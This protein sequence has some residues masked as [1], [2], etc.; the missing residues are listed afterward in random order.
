VTEI[1]TQGV[2][3]GPTGTIGEPVYLS[4]FIPLTHSPRKTDRFLLRDLYLREGKTASQISEQTGLSKQAVLARLRSAGVRKTADRGR[5]PDNFRYPVPPYGYRINEG[6]LV[7]SPREMKVARLI[8]EMRDR[9][10][11]DWAAIVQRLNEKGFRSRTGLLWNRV[12]VKRVHRYWSGK[13]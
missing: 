3:F 7:A 8:V 11:A 13:L 12:R 4:D 9:Q 6:R 10:K 1:I 5:S 2:D